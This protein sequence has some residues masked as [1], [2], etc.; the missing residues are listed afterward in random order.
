MRDRAW[1]ARVVGALLILVPFIPVRAEGFGYVP[2]T[3]W[4]LGLVIFGG[5]AWLVARYIPALPDAC[6]RGAAAI[7]D[8][9]LAGRRTSKSPR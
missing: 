9:P 3:E 2:P 6:L 7:N 8:G 5:I 4:L 1:V